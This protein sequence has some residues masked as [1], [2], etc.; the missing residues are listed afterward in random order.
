MEVSQFHQQQCDDK[1]AGCMLKQKVPNFFH[2]TFTK[3]FK[4][5]AKGLMFAQ[6]AM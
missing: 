3:T 6:S 5:Y 1:P 4:K 2:D